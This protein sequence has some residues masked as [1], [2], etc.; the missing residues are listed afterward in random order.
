MDTQSHIGRMLVCDSID[1]SWALH[2]KKMTTYGFDRL[3]YGSTRLK[4]H[5]MMGDISDALILLEGNQEYTDVYIGDELYL[6][7]PVN[8]WAENN[9]GSKSWGD[10]A[11]SYD[12]AN[13]SEKRL[14][15]LQLN[16]KWGLVAGW[17]ISLIDTNR[18]SKGTIGLCARRGLSQQDADDIWKEHGQEIEMLNNILHLKICTLPQSGQRRPLTTRQIEAL[19]WYGDGKTTRDIATIMSLSAATVEKH[20]RQARDSLNVE[21][22]AHAVQKA[23]SLNQLFG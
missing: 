8:S 4:T 6:E 20:L 13:I 23:T 7:S 2:V 9:S 5:G 17:S 10:F 14:K 18:R 19:R 21:T 11:A 1:E 16:I 22:T 3:L 15:L 12:V